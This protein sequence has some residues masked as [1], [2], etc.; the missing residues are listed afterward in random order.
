MAAFAKSWPG[1]YKRRIKP[2]GSVDV[3]SAGQ[4]HREGVENLPR[5]RPTTEPDLCI[6]AIAMTISRAGARLLTHQ[7]FCGGSLFDR[8]CFDLGL[9][10][11]LIGFVQQPI[12][13]A[14]TLLLLDPSVL[15]FLLLFSEKFVVDFPTH[16]ILHL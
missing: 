4:R 2:L 5:A 10:A 3:A 11:L 6:H 16:W 8:R 1:K 7:L 15:R 13:D 14:G 9:L 12:E